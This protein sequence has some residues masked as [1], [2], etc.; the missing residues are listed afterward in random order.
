ML[1]IGDSADSVAAGYNKAQEAISSGAA[2]EKFRQIV[3]LQGGDPKAIDYPKRLPKAK[4]TV[5]FTAS[6]SGYIA[7]VDCERVGTASVVLGGG[8]E[9]KEDAVDPAVGLVIHKKLSDQV[10]ADE[11]IC[12][13]HYNSSARLEEALG[14]LR[15]AYHIAPVAPELPRTLIHQ[16]IGL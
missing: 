11:P 2:R 10:S 15:S 3:E 8:R 16:V 14:L 12:T 1:H 4:H 7:S 6:Q 5:E 13:V 9:K